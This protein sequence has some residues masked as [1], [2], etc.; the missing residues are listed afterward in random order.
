MPWM[1][2]TG[3]VTAE[4]ADAEDWATYEARMLTTDDLAHPAGGGAREDH[5]VHRSGSPRMELFEGGLARGLT[6]AP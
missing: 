1:V 2:E 5:R 4:W 6:L 3:A